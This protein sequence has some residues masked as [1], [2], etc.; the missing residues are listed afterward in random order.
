MQST[1]GY[2]FLKRNITPREIL[3]SV[4]LPKA[5]GLRNQAW[6]MFCLTLRKILESVNLPKAYGLRSQA[7]PRFC[8]TL[9]KKSE[10]LIYPRHVVR[11]ARHGK[12]S[13]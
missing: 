2:K 10:V 1:G 3:E 11:E 12:C 5:C 4:N 9:R 6:S 13:V 8:L 7:W